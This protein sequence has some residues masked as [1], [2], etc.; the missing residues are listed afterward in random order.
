MI[1]PTFDS[2]L[3]WLHL[4]SAAVWVGGQIVLGGIVPTVRRQ[5][6]DALRH[7]AQ[8][9]ARIA[10]PAM[11]VLVLTGMWRL[12]IESPS[13]QSGAWLATLAFKLLLVGASI[14][15][16]LAHSV[17]RTRLVIAIGG[18][19]GLLAALGAM[20]LGVLLAHAG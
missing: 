11:A 6:P 4:L 8:A 15:A 1:S 13:E 16:T 19:V 17:S 12:A 20:Y 9:F 2:L 18:A 5:S 7:V 3:T 10:W 14:A